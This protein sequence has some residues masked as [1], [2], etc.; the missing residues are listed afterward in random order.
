LGDA[1]VA[2]RIVVEYL[3]AGGT[4]VRRTHIFPNHHF[5]NRCIY[6]QKMSEHDL[7]QRGQEIAFD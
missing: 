4:L 1:P 6:F 2:D 7:S 5:D 3:V